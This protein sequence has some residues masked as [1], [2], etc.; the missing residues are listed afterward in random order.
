M[1]YRTRDQHLPEWAKPRS[2]GI[3][4]DVAP[5]AHV[6]YLIQHRRSLTLVCWRC[7]RRGVLS[8]EQLNASAAHG[9]DEP[10]WRFVGRCRCS[11]C[12]AGSPKFE[13]EGVPR[14]MLHGTR[15][16]RRG[17]LP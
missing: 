9:P 10:M 7:K 13:Y 5:D 11:A 17:N 6:G 8:P 15:Y 2:G 1:G 4:A 14:P 3:E 12:Q 16:S